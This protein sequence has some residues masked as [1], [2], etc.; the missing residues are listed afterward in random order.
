MYSRMRYCL[1]KRDQIQSNTSFYYCPQ[2]KLRKLIFLHLSVI[3]FTGGLC[4]PACITGH[5]T[6]QH[7]ISSCI[8][9]DSQLVL[10]QHTGNIKCIME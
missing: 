1:S 7:Y 9:V 8:G 3:L 2:T 6:N 4:I 10:G 5:M